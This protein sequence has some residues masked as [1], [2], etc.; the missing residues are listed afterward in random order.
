MSGLMLCVIHL[1][2]CSKWKTLTNQIFSLISLKY[3]VFNYAINSIM[4]NGIL[5]EQ[6]HKASIT[7]FIKNK[8]INMYLVWN[9]YFEGLLLKFYAAIFKKQE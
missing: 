7:N 1:P 3:L 2:A 6:W 4:I 5:L 9:K 8:S